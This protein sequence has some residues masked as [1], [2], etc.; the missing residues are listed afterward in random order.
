[1]L[2]VS[3]KDTYL[4]DKAIHSRK[5]HS[6]RGQLVMPYQ[7]SVKPRI[8][9]AG[10]DTEALYQLY[11]TADVATNRPLGR[12]CKLRRVERMLK[13]SDCNLPVK[14]MSNCS[15]EMYEYVY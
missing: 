5:C 14:A 11:S 12:S 7:N 13:R 8:E 6:F 1:M 15:Y 3:R 10:E 2:S 4:S 9:V